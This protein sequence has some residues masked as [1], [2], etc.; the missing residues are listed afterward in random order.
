[1]KKVALLFLLNG[2]VSGTYS[3]EIEV[4]VNKKGNLSY[5]NEPTICINRK[6]SLKLQ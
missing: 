5:P 4:L 1:M 3:Q 6:D 2:L